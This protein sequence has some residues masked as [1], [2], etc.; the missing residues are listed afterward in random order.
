M[1]SRFATW[2]SLGITFALAA[3]FYLAAYS[4]MR[5][6]QTTRGPWEVAF[7]TNNVGV[8]QILIQQPA[9]GLSNITIQF[10]GEALGATNTTGTV[11]FAQPRQSTP[12]GRL[13]YDDLMFLPGI[14]TLDCF[15]HLVELAPPRLG[16]N[17]I[18][19]DWSNN[20]QHTLW[21]TNKM[22]PELRQ[23]LKGGYK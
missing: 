9:L 2:K 17:G 6:R 14:V 16:L 20:V 11:R 3:G 22:A 7:A 18:G 15:G 13:V 12:F 8:P 23:R 4:C 21:P 19:L 10:S 5:H 1:K